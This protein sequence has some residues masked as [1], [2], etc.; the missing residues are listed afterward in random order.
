MIKRKRRT[1]EQQRWRAAAL[2]TFASD[3]RSFVLGTLCF[4]VPAA[5]ALLLPMPDLVK[6]LIVGIMGASWAWMLYVVAA[7]ANY[8]AT[9]G[10]WGEDFTREV[11][12]AQRPRWAAVHDLPLEKHNI[13]HIVVTPRAV[14]AIETK[15]LGKG[16]EWE[17]LDAHR[18]IRQA[19]R[20]A[21]DAAALIRQAK[22][23][24][25]VQVTPVLMLWGPGAPHWDEHSQWRDDVCVVQGSQAK[26]WAAEWAH[27]EITTDVAARVCNALTAFQA[28]RD[29]YDKRTA[30][31]S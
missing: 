30:G 13:D 18:D 14:L 26:A 21:R 5:V 10:S 3:R 15:F 24:V 27:G 11:I 17:A 8:S 25:N 22:I 28:R 31:R 23:G 7:L 2:G 16:R 20:G 12:E 6:G 29:S 1:Y 9:M 19:A 4:L